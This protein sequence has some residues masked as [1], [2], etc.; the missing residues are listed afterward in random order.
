[1]GS[2]FPIMPVHFWQILTN[3][4]RT[5]W[6]DLLANPA[7]SH[8]FQISVQQRIQSIAGRNAE[9]QTDYL[10]IPLLLRY[11]IGGIL[12]L[13]AGRSSVS[14]NKDKTLLQ[15]GQS[16]FKDGDFAW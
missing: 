15:N 1:M 2:T 10:S 13:N 8:Q 11:N 14:F 4:A 16:A 3:G 6:I 5:T 7:R 12:S 9:H